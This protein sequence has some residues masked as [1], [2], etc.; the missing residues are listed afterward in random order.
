MIV[1]YPK[2]NFINIMRNPIKFSSI[3]L[4]DSYV[5]QQI[6][7]IRASFLYTNEVNSYKAWL[8]IQ[9]I[10]WLSSKYIRHFIKMYKK[11]NRHTQPHRQERNYEFYLKMCVCVC[12]SGSSECQKCKRETEQRSLLGT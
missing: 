4:H 10:Q 11:G 5:N 1:R 3:S 9:A 8:P 6:Q 7:G 12:S 2:E